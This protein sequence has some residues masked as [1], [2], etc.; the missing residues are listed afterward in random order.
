M[1]T[2]PNIAEAIDH[3]GLFGPWF[4]GASWNGWRAIIKAAYSLPMSE[5]E[6][7]LFKTI[8]GDGQ[9][10]APS[11]GCHSIMPAGSRPAERPGRH[12]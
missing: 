3:A 9:G 7:A 10:W 5:A 2:L 8:A 6:V 4:A 12:K 1:S 11:A